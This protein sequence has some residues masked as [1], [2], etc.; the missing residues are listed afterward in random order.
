MLELNALPHT[1]YTLTN[2]HGLDLFVRF[3]GED[4]DKPLALVA[5]GFTDVHDTGHMRAVASALIGQG[6]NVLVWDATHSWGRSGGSIDQATLTDMYEDM[7]DIV[8][9]AK[10]QSWFHGPFFLCGYS[11]GAAAAL[12]YAVDHPEDVTRL[13]VIAPVVAGELLAKRLNPIIRGVWRVLGR[14]PDPS[15][16][17]RWYRYSLLYDGLRYDGR[18]LVKKLNRPVTI[19]AADHDN[20]MPPSDI[21]QLYGAIP[22]EKRLIMIDGADHS[23]AQKLP[24]LE[25]AITASV[26][27]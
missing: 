20:L 24:Q 25:A 14:V 11:M 7:V 12:R 6:Y 8:L 13:T 5:H 9:W 22:H 4:N 21:A 3:N 26:Q 1:T 19:I 16:R 17:G 23:F 2:R 18:K 15:M 10:Q 27:P